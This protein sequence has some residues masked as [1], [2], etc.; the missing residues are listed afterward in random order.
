MEQ[1]KL[2]NICILRLSAIGDVCHA[3][4]AVQAIQLRHTEASITWIIGKIEYKLLEGLAGVEFVIFD[5]SQGRQAYKKLK[6]DLNGKE[7]DVLLHM[8]VSLR[9]NIAAKLIR[10]KRKIGYDW[11]R[12]KELHSLFINERIKAQTQAH[13]LE[14]F[15]AFAEQIGVPESAKHKLSWNIPVS[16]DDILLAEIHIPDGQH[17]FIIA[18]SASKA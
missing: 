18:P 11:L 1:T 8:Q 6:S 17:T 16:S 4:A 14:S 13:V 7:F 2:N 5:K 12:A 3:V 15:F 9:A 10:A